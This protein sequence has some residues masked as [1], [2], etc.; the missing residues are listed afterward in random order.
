MAKLA[1]RKID[2]NRFTKI[3]PYVR[4]PPRF[5][6]QYDQIIGE[7]SVEAG[8]II[9]TDTDT[10]T[11]TYVAT[12]ASVP[13]VVISTVDTAGNSQTNVSVTITSITTTQVTVTASSNFTGQVHVHVASI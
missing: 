11:Y 6:Y 5:V 12:Y 1:Y 8:K 7:S 3:Y 9:F 13:S 2:R 10:G 4:F